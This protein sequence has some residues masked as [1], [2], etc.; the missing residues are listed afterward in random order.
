M[1]IKD[2][3]LKNSHHE[4]WKKRKKERKKEKFKYKSGWNMFC[5]AYNVFIA[6]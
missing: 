1:P 3:K 4:K 6:S 2:A 5:Q